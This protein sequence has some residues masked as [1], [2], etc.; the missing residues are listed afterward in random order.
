MYNMRKKL[1]LNAI[2]IIIITTTLKGTT[3]I[4]FAKQS[5]NHIHRLNLTPKTL[6]CI[7]G[8]T[9]HNLLIHER[10]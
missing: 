8:I 5:S 3:S 4:P 7:A 9:C 10:N 1:G 6:P 2:I